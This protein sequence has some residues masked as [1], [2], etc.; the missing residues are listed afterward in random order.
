MANFV[1]YAGPLAMSET[2][3]EETA[4][5]VASELERLREVR[6]AAKRLLAGRP[7]R[8]D[9]EPSD[10][11]DELRKAVFGADLAGW[12]AHRPMRPEDVPRWLGE[13]PGP[14]GKAMRLW[15]EGNLAI[16]TDGHALLAMRDVHVVE[17]GRPPNHSD[18]TGPA[19]RVI[20]EV[21]WNTAMLV[22]QRD[23]SV[24]LAAA[25]G[26]A[27]ER[28][29]LGQC[30]PIGVGPQTR[31]DP[32][33]VERFVPRLDPDALFAVSFGPGPCDPI[34]FRPY[35]HRHSGAWSVVIMPQRYGEGASVPEQS[36]PLTAPPF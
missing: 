32:E 36:L 15:M 2:E 14:E 29:V 4:A 12:R 26:D 27:P 7:K 33:L 34:G 18:G 22:S 16:V 10:G 35:D 17:R 20:S 28:A 1:K 6:A 13:W 25:L 19:A 9:D 31:V 24:V 30:D 11:L 23:L 5:W 3:A 8:D 21:D